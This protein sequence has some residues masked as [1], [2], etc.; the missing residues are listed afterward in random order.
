MIKMNNNVQTL[1]PL[2]TKS[3]IF[4]LRNLYKNIW[5]SYK[6]TW[7]VQDRRRFKYMTVIRIKMSVYY[8]VVCIV[9]FQKSYIIITYGQR[10]YTRINC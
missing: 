5:F 6:V 8:Y 7:L 1:S 4:Q 9:V 10:L 2:S 3:L